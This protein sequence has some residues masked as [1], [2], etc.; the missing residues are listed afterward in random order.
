LIG[1]IAIEDSRG[2]RNVDP[3]EF[4]LSIGGPDAD[5]RLHGVP[6][7]EPV[8]W[9]GIAEGDL[10]IQAGQSG[11]R[12]ICNGDPVAASQ[13]LR[14]GDLVRIGA[15]RIRIDAA[16]GGLILK[17]ERLQERDLTRP[18]A[19]VVPKTVAPAAGDSPAALIRAVEFRP[20]LTHGG[21]RRPHRMPW[22][23]LG[24]VLAVAVAAVPIWFV[25]TARAIRVEIEPEP[26]RM[27]LRTGLTGFRFGGRY[28]LKPGRYE[29]SAEK[30][31]YRTLQ[32]VVEVGE[33]RGRIFRFTLERLPGYLVIDT[34]GVTG[35][36]VRIDGEVVGATP[37]D[38]V[39]LAAG[40]YDVRIVAER[41]LEF[42]ERVTII[43]GG[44]TRTLRADLPPGWAA[45]TFL[46]EPP[47]AVVRIGGRTVGA[48]PLTAEI[49]AG[50]HRV[51]YS[52]ER[53]RI[54]SDTLKV[55][56]GHPRI[57]PAAILVP[58]D[59]TL[60]VAS[61]PPGAAVTVNDEY[62]GET[63]VEIQLPPDRIH[64]VELSR[65]GHESNER[66][67]RLE[68]GEF[69]RLAVDLT[70][71]VGE[72][73]IR[74]DPDGAEVWVGGEQIGR[75]GGILQLAAIPQEI[76]IRKAGFETYR[77]MVT[78]RPGISQVIRVTLRSM[79]EIEEEKT[80]AVMQTSLGQTLVYVEGGRL[81]MG[82]P[83]REPGR[84][85][86]ETER[87]VE[88][89]RPFYIG[90][91][92]VSN[93]EF[94]QFNSK[95]TSGVVGRHS[96]DIDDHPVVRV[97]WEDAALFCNWL[98]QREGRR[99]AYVRAGGRIVPVMPPTT[100][101]RLP[102]EAE[103][104]LTAR[105]AATGPLKYPWGPSMPVPPESGNYADTSASSL[106]SANLTGYDDTFPATAPVDSFAPNVLGLYNMG[107]NVAEWVQDL[108]TIYPAGGEIVR[109]PLG[110]EEGELYVIR[111]SSWMDSSVSELRL[112]YRDYG[113]DGRPDVGFRIARYAE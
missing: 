59:G 71:I 36:V 93:R 63:P 1:P 25:F 108:F 88:L 50:S 8:G 28:L 40:D 102:T 9:F 79:Q 98:S 6:G 107:G 45:I 55:V 26:D 34:S 90:A 24:V 103:W 91:V 86:N 33:E 80:P 72:V 58:A 20:R 110:P 66:R 27:V 99:P 75:T 68:P 84:R 15:T 5:I 95:H 21:R 12:I 65:A 29:L 82:A 10:F 4:P 43:G 52:L 57:L 23:S 70:V 85:A 96:L 49:G 112:T 44:E 42:E 17:I 31:G 11:E 30:E 3:G 81:R 46:S 13:W 64:A 51:E 2:V 67:V 92:E 53:Y 74:T 56:A 105:Y 62:R 101:Y 41:F 54:H 14:A 7:L 60:A 76:E 19:I 83:R 77:A 94:R 69:R 35:A 109:D 37:L 32:E 97:S 38:P 106:L 73:E 104:A 100:G 87:E 111:G 16:A 18:P 48:T 47:G 78:P 22:R 89:T 113:S 61:V 39:E